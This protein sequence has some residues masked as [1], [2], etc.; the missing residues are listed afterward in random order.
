[1]ERTLL[2][3]QEVKVVPCSFPRQHVDRGLD[4]QVPFGFL[5]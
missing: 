4:L 3:D 1:M 2:K 5:F